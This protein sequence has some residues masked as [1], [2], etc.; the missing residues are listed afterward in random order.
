MKGIV[1]ELRLATRAL[2][3]EPRFA[4]AVVGSLALGISTNTAIFSLASAV[5]LRP[6]PVK[7]GLVHVSRTWSEDDA[8][9]S[10]SPSDFAALCKRKDVFA[11]MAV[12]V[13]ARRTILVEGSPEELQ[14]SRVTPNFFPLVGVE[15][16]LGRKLLPEDAAAGAPP[17]ILVSSRLWHRR[18]DGRPTAVGQSVRLNDELCEIV[19]VL[20][21]EWERVDDSDFWRIYRPADD[22]SN[23]NSFLNNV[24]A[25]LAPGLSTGAAEAAATV[26]VAGLVRDAGAG[27]SRRV[28]IHLAP[29][30]RH[31]VGDFLQP[32]F[33]LLGAAGLVLL[34][35]CANTANLL[36]ARVAGRQREIAIRKALGATSGDLAAHSLS[37]ATVLAATGAALALPLAIWETRLLAAAAPA[38]IWQ[39][40]NA[41][42]DGRVL[43]FCAVLSLMTALL[44]GLIP[45]LWSSRVAPG[46]ALQSRGKLVRSPFGRRR[47]G[48]V[49]VVSEV[50][51]AFPLFVA[52]LLMME[53]LWHLQRADLGFARER[54]LVSRI[55][56]PRY[57]YPDEPARRRFFGQLL[58]RMRRQ[59]GVESAGII[60]FLPI[61]PFGSDHRPVRL[62]GTAG[63][64]LDAMEKIV[65]GEY[66]RT[67]GIP[68]LRG[69]TFTDFDDERSGAVAVIS[70]STRRH[71][72]PAEDPIG[73]TLEAWFPFG[74]CPRLEPPSDNCGDRWESV[75]VVGVVGDVASW[76]ETRIDSG[77]YLAYRQ[78]IVP[79]MSLVIRTSSPAIAVEP[80]IRR[81]VAAL[82]PAQTVEPPR[83]LRNVLLG[84]IALP[85]FLTL[86]LRLFGGLA[87]V[88][89]ATGTYAVLSSLVAHRRTEIGIRT[90]LGAKPRDVVALFVGQS[91]RWTAVGI[92]LGAAVSV[93]ST[94]LLG[95]VLF[96]L[97][98]TDPGTF[99]LGA[100]V[101]GGAGVLGAYVPARRAAQVDPTVALRSE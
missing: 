57:K 26:T 83:P 8:S 10:L 66:F 78:Q 70:E 3:R 97:T 73:R 99:A 79:T 54:L 21:P 82:D 94:R 50:A 60:H 62:P 7:P 36:L 44:V 68:I 38:G 34:I 43:G 4:F 1:R 87:L 6:L 74:N 69:R 12:S 72:F 56:L 75:T 86:I 51:L 63:A 22:L 16:I 9:G 24:V 81:G 53:S 41:S 101:L 59:P 32:L 77:I 95:S 64:Q 30:R 29:I 37:E 88:L 48:G 52:A 39:I 42:F 55:W 33:A 14:G 18:F 28:G 49:L 89:A 15:P 91:L 58:D 92:A 5:L 67:T 45:V 76:P 71:F 84:E 31:L 25:R 40:R 27:A 2:W 96:G 23:T 46:E 61:G 19:G 98:P 65:D 80:V 17:T 13:G 85:R 100:C 11:E 90:A 35:V 20:P 47:A 93:A